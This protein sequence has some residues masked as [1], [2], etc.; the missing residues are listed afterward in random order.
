MIHRTTFSRFA[1]VNG[2]DFV[3]LFVFAGTL[4][5]NNSR[6]SGTVAVAGGATPFSLKCSSNWVLFRLQI[7]DRV[8]FPIS[9]VA[10]ELPV[11]VYDVVNLHFGNWQHP[12]KSW[13]V[14]RLACST[15]VWLHN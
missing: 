3:L 1:C 10:V 12:Q 4:P 8:R 13:R 14:V 5:R 2:L 6:S 11:A 15:I 7:M 9:V